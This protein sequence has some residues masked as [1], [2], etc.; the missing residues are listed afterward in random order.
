[1]LKKRYDKKRIIIQRH[2][3]AL[4]QLQSVSKENFMSLC[5]LVDEVLRDYLHSALKA[6]GRPTDSWDDIIIHLITSK[7][8]HITNKEWE[9]NILDEDIPTI[10]H[11]TDF[12]E[13]RC[14]L[15]LQ[16]SVD[17]SIVGVNN[18][19]NKIKKTVQVQLSSRH[20][21]FK[22]V[23]ECLVLNRITE[24]L[25]SVT[26]DKTAFKIPQ[27]LPLAN[28]EFYRSTDID[29][30]LGAEMFWN[31]L[32]VGQIK[33][34]S[35]Y[36]LLQKTLFGWVIGGKYPG[37]SVQQKTIQCNAD[38][39]K[40]EQLVENFWQIEQIS[41]KPMLTNEEKDCEET[42]GSCY[43][44]ALKRF[45]LLEFKLDRCPEMTKEYAKFIQEYLELKHML[46]VITEN[47]RDNPV[48]YM[49]HHA[50]ST[51]RLRVV[52]DASSKTDTGVSLNDILLVGP[53]L[54]K[55]LTSIL[56]RLR[57]WQYVLTA[58]VEKMY[59]HVQIDESQRGLQ[60][61]LWRNNSHE[62]VQTFELVT[63]TYGTASASFLAVRV[64]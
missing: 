61:I 33:E 3:R 21:A 36:P 19:C 54:Q 30:L 14:I 56:I 32:C 62:E 48:Y 42:L 44:T 2:I 50:V 49:P 45:K 40:L 13:H 9:N 16:R 55:D 6:I 37:S 29:I 5:Y 60:R 52:F 17:I 7:L 58:D 53:N 22:V 20:Y 15:V 46:P 35:D 31:I 34:S 59:W 11:L 51:I 8:D 4:F 41:D 23:I 64:F 47:T 25:P 38:K 18:S 57:L 24:R 63:L 12:L 43:N 28:P 39:A 27:N 1:M 10:R 26:I